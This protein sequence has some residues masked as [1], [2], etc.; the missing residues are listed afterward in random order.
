MYLINGI[1]L[2]SIYNWKKSEGSIEKKYDKDLH[3]KTKA[4]NKST[5]FL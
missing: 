3:V 1:E 4:L 2:A 5:I